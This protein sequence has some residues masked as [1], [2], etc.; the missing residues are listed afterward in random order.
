MLKKYADHNAGEGKVSGTFND[1]AGVMSVSVMV[2]KTD[3]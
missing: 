1:T 2:R 3:R